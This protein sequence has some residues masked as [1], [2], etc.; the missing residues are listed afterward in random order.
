LHEIFLISAACWWVRPVVAQ[1]VPSAPSSAHVED[2]RQIVIPITGLK[3]GFRSGSLPLKPNPLAIALSH[4]ALKGSF[5]TG[6]CLDPA[7]RFIGT[8]YHVVAMAH[9]IKIKGERIVHQYLATGPDDVGTT[10]TDIPNMDS[11][12]FNLSRD[13]AI[14]ELERPLPHHHGIPFNLD[15]MEPGQEVDIYSYPKNEGIDPRR[16]L[17]SFH[18]RYEG[19]T[20]TG[21]LAFRYSY[22]GDRWLKPGSSGGIV[23]DSKT[24]QMV[25]IL[26]AVAKS[27]ETV[28]LAVPIQSLADFVRKTQPFL[29]QA[30]FHE[31]EQISPVAADLYPK[32]VP[33][34]A[35]LQHRPEEPYEIWLLRIKAQEL[36]DSM[37]NYTA[38]QSFEWGIG[39]GEPR[40]I[41]DYEVRVVDGKQLFRLFPDGKKDYVDNVPLLPWTFAYAP[42]SEW[43]V[44]PLMV[45]TEFRLNIHQAADAMVNGRRVLVFQYRASEEDELCGWD[46]MDDFVFFKTHKV[47]KTA[48]HGEVWTDEKE[49][50]L[51]IS[52][53][54]E[55]EKHP[56]R[57]I[58]TYGWIRSELGR[59]LVPLTISTKTEYKNRTY[60]CRGQFSDYRLFSSQIKIVSSKPVP[61]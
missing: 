38:M 34:P 21:L 28:A 56:F 36:A 31:S 17:E 16:G 8:N 37:R 57:A 53:E 15:E 43:S 45:G 47:V 40:A 59:A 3:L 58:V 6:F 60:W 42:A 11:L 29:A 26:S 51:R 24:Q 5:A 12:R 20:T 50:I 39:N 49:N 55:Y 25:G 14:F 18:G 46:I 41:R 30:L 4:V 23:V 48:C 9:P 54:Y 19:V 27:E 13:I 32:F 44:L 61:D 35:E 52:E 2:F 1:E 33:P 22:G 7:C 10:I